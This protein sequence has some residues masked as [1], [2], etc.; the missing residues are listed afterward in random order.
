MAPELV[1]ECHAELT[2]LADAGLIAPLVSERLALA[3]VPDGLQRLADGVTVG[4]VVYDG[5]VR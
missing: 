3:D 4:R 5:G 2:R 1:G